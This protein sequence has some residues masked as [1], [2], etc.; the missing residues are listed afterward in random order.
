LQRVA[1]SDRFR[2]IGKSHYKASGFPVP[3]ES[4]RVFHS[5]P[6]FQTESFLYADEVDGD[7]PGYRP[8]SSRV[9][10]RRIVPRATKTPKLAAAVPVFNSFLACMEDGLLAAEVDLWVA[11][12][13]VEEKNCRCVLRARVAIEDGKAIYLN[14]SIRS[15]RLAHLLLSCGCEG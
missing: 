14:C 2:N 6:S 9:G 3:N 13:P 4:R 1:F 11:A 7:I 10:Y 15:W 12:S 8:K 5:V